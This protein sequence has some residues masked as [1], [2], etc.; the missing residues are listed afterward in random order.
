MKIS[1]NPIEIIK[2]F[3]EARALNK[4]EIVV[5]VSEIADEAEKLED[6]WE[7]IGRKL[8]ANETFNENDIMDLR[9][10]MIPD[11][12][13]S[14]NNSEYTK[15]L[16]FYSHTSR[17]LGNKINGY[18]LNEIYHQLGS[19]LHYRKLSNKSFKSIF[20]MTSNPL[21]FNQDN[22]ELEINNILDYI[23]VLRNEASTLRIIAKNMKLENIR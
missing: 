23:N 14:P 11:Y 21:F 9:K 17:A 22:Y 20:K 16:R 13:I 4:K 1:I 7:C 10:M 3:I 12:A 2:S 18:W 8:A 5:Y 19:V 6:I 15:L